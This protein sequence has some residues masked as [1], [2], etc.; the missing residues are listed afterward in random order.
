MNEWFLKIAASLFENIF[1][2]LFL[3]K[4]GGM[5]RGNSWGERLVVDGS[6]FVINLGCKGWSVSRLVVSVWKHNNAS[7]QAQWKGW[8]KERGSF[9]SVCERSAS[10]ASS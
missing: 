8:P 10:A 5:E 4:L 6:I 7:K 3:I 2:L 9:S 1:S